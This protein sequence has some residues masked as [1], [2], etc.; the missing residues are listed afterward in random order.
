MDNEPDNPKNCMFF[1]VADAP[2]K[3]G[4][5]SPE[6]LSTFDGLAERIKKHYDIRNDIDFEWE[7]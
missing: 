4:I 2:P 1:D 7:E 3:H 6:K 5:P